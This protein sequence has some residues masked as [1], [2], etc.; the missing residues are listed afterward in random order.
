MK[1]HST[2]VSPSFS[3]QSHRSL[4]FCKE[5]LKHYE[6]SAVSAAP[7]FSAAFCEPMAWSEEAVTT[8]PLA[9]GRT[10]YR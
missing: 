3:A 6:H 9:D 4:Y 7:P 10:K 5:H 2:G 8:A 1:M